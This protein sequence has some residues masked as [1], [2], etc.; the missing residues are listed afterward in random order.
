LRYA[1]PGPKKPMTKIPI[2]G[3]VD[4]WKG[5]GPRTVP[6][7]KEGTVPTLATCRRGA[8]SKSVLKRKSG[9]CNGPLL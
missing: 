2:K 4:S 9:A 7:K 1:G 6:Q 8:G 3:G 5:T